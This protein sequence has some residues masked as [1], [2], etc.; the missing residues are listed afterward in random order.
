MRAGC[1][2]RL[3]R[4]LKTART[5]RATTT[6]VVASAYHIAYDSVVRFSAHV[7]SA[8]KIARTRKA[9]STR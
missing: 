1:A 3:C 6:T 2:I 7:T 9:P 5:L 4:C 8:G